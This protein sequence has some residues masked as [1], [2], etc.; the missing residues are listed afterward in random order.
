MNANS[1][2]VIRADPHPCCDLCG[3][4]GEIVHAH[5]R[6]HLFGAYGTWNLKRCVNAACGMMWLD[7]MPAPEEIAKA[8]ETYY[9]HSDAPERMP[10]SLR[11]WASKFGEAYLARRYAYRSDK[12]TKYWEWLSWLIYLHPGARASLDFSVFYLPQRVQGRLLE[13]GFGSGR[14]LAA[15][16]LR[17]W[18]V[19]GVDMD[20]LAVGNARR[21]GLVVHHGTLEQQRFPAEE[22]DAIVMSHVI[23]HVPSPLEVIQHC[24]RLLKPD[25]VLVLITPNI[26]SWGHRRYG[27]YW[28]G[29]EP[30]RHLHIFNPRTMRSLASTAGFRHHQ[31]S[32]TVRDTNGLF[33]AS[34]WLKKIANGHTTGRAPHRLVYY[35]ARLLQLVEWALLKFRPDSGE[36]MVAVMTK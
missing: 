13:I 30:P 9:T 16:A 12:I 33:L 14:M 36:E 35:R 10:S 7:P 22:F 3:N 1:S 26:D 4:L 15:M 31:V 2:P 21:K 24:R 34:D 23:E 25:G 5:L 11:S 8:Y 18:N 20:P 27:R 17:G 28:R 19:E 32:T 29:L 6:D